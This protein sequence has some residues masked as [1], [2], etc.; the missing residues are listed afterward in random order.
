MPPFSSRGGGGHIYG[1]NY[2]QKN[3]DNICTGVSSWLQIRW[4]ALMTRPSHPVIVSSLPPV[5][6]RTSLSFMSDQICK[7]RMLIISI[8]KRCSYNSPTQRSH[9]QSNP[10][11]PTYSSKAR[12]THDVIYFE[13]AIVQ[14]PQKQCS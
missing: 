14:G 12:K 9:T 6:T 8:A 10:I 2:T 13:K 1:N 11:H 3:L 4:S 7:K 5:V